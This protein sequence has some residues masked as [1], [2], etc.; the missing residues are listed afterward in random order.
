VP[1][2][3]MLYGRAPAV[4]IVAALTLTVS[5]A[6]Q[7]VISTHSGVVHFFEGAV[8]ID[9]QPLESHLGKFAVVP[10]GG[11]LHTAKGRAEVLLTPGVF[12][13]LGD[14]SAIRMIANTLTDT[15]VELLSGSAIV[16]SAE[17]TAGTS[18]A[19]IYKSWSVRFLEPGTYRMDS[20]PP[21]LWVIQGKAE[22]AAGDKAALTVEQGMSLPFA[23]VLV[24][25]RTILQPNDMLSMWD[26]GRKQSIDADNAIAANIQDPASLDASNSGVDGFTNYPLLSMT[27]LGPGIS[28]YS[29]LGIYEP[30]FNSIYLPGYT[31]LPIFLGLGFGGPRVP[32]RQPPIRIGS[33]YLPPVGLPPGRLPP[34]RLP[35]GLPPMR[36]PAHAG[37]LPYSLPRA[38]V[39]RMVPIRPISPPAAVAPIHSAS[40]VGIHGGVHR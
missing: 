19:L 23:S 8:S 30:G 5:A 20:D 27:S 39:P 4:W 31:V 11:E 28:T 37:F 15:R 9:G 22:V 2:D 35:P 12:L 18:V 16:D 21:R 3:L 7:S 6:A 32:V 13:R 1:G 26:E 34:G 17:P 40:P 10:Q 24:P 33:G 29:S 38:S 36:I 25:D 14:S